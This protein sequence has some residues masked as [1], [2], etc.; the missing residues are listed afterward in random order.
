LA[1]GYLAQDGGDVETELG[2]QV[3]VLV[4]VDLLRELCIGPVDLV[5]PPLLAKQVKD[6]VLVYLHKHLVMGC[7]SRSPVDAQ[8]RRGNPSELMQPRSRQVSPVDGPNLPLRGAPRALPLRRL[9][10]SLVV[11]F[12]V[13]GALAHVDREPLS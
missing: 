3:G 2:Q 5:R 6:L 9:R 8:E 11:G 1:A 13:L 7:E 4:S 12:V 10:A